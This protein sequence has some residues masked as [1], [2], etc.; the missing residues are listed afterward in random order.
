MPSFLLETRETKLDRIDANLKWQASI[1][2]PTPEERDREIY[3]AVYIQRRKPAKVAREWNLAP[4]TV[5]NIARQTRDALARREHELDKLLKSQ[6]LKAFYDE[7]FDQA[8]ELR[9]SWEA[10]KGGQ[11]TLMV[12]D[13]HSEPI[14]E[15]IRNQGIGDVRL[16]RLMHQISEK[17]QKIEAR[18]A[19][20]D[21]P[22]E[23]EGRAAGVSLLEEEAVALDRGTGGVGTGGD[24]AAAVPTPAPSPTPTLA[25]TPPPS[26]EP[27][28]LQKSKS[29]ESS[30]QS[31]SKSRRRRIG[32]SRGG[33]GDVITS[34]PEG[35]STGSQELD[36]Q[37]LAALN[38]LPF[39]PEP[40]GCGDG[41]P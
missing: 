28:S 6:S 41:G 37:L 19:V 39:P 9:E 27:P 30:P 13:G 24:T 10:S 20:D 21:L 2:L 4:I 31:K 15:T 14:R 36:R 3:E 18:F 12:T 8:R 35:V 17:M 40:C 5:K 22:E 7:L 29:G 1:P 25:L 26:P 34:L 11:T 32:R 23:P 38:G 16:M 33:L